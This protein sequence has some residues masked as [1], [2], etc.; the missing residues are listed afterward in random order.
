MKRRNFWDS[1]HKAFILQMFRE[2]FFYAEGAMKWLD[3]SAP[4]TSESG[5]K[6]TLS[7]LHWKFWYLWNFCIKWNI[8]DINILLR[9]DI[10]KFRYC[11]HILIPAEIEVMY[12]FPVLTHYLTV[13]ICLCANWN[14][15]MLTI[16]PNNSCFMFF[17]SSQLPTF[18]FEYNINVTAFNSYC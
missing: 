11:L 12:W 3:E 14:I 1:F 4:S 13:F 16:F 17:T 6:C 15:P 7:L 8:V 9:E 5:V 18:Y 2:S 10:K